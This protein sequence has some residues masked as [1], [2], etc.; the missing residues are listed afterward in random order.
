MKITPEE[1]NKKNKYYPSEKLIVNNKIMCTKC[2][3]DEADCY[4]IGSYYCVGLCD[5]CKKKSDMERAKYGNLGGYEFTTE[6]IKEQ[7]KSHF[8]S[9]LQPWREGIPSK[10]FAEAYPDKAKKLFKGDINKARYVWRDSPGW[11]NRD[12][13]I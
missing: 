11:N 4:I 3:K 13:S 5:T 8:K 10:E 1:F 12:K 2:G 7:R 9:Q 6:S